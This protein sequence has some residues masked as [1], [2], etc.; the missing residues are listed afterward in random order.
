MTERLIPKGCYAS[1][2]YE[3]EMSK[4][5]KIFEN[6]LFRWIALKE[7]KLNPIGIGMIAIYDRQYYEKE[8]L[9]ILV[10]VND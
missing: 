8:V 3:G 2:L 6:D 1:F 10:P 4:I 9:K 7:I 5:R